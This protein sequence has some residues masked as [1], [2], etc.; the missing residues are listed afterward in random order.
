MVEER[1]AGET[2]ALTD[3][4]VRAALADEWRERNPQTPA[5]IAAFYRESKHLADDLTVFH[6][7]SGRQ[8]WTECIVWVAKEQGVRRVVDIG[9]G[10]GHDLKALREAIPGIDL[11]GI[12]P[13]ERLSASFFETSG[14]P[15]IPVNADVADAP[16]ES[17][18][19][20][21]MI[22]VLEHIPDPESFLTGVATRAPLGCFA[23]EATA[24]HDHGTPLH[25][26]A[27]WA[28]H[29]GHAFEAA[30]WERQTQEGRLRV[31]KRVRE[32]AEPRATLMLMAQSSCTLPTMRSILDLTAAYRDDGW[33]IYMGGEAGINRARNIAASRWYRETGDDVFVMVDHDI[34][35]TP[36]DV[37]RLVDRCRNGYPI[38][39][40]AYPVRDGGH[41]AMKAKIG[42]ITFGG[43]KEPVEIECVAT[44]FLA[45]HRR[46]IEAV[47]RDLPLCH[48]NT[49]WA[50]W[51]LFPFEVVENED[52]GGY[53]MLSE[54]YGWSRLAQRYGFKSYVD[55]S[56]ILR[57]LGTIPI[58]I[59][60]MGTV[61]Q[62]IKMVNG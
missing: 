35:F 38:I 39:C 49:E 12:E 11:C 62:A 42:Q 34:V 50:F 58:G 37:M 16:I 53:E 9:C 18:D 26:K 17:A 7:N 31:W 29:P 40:G 22:D 5:E 15:P 57:H 25:L 44:G 55:P 47:I 3:K 61:Q 36:A 8:R 46:V 1:P 10:L 45:V 21:I 56:I 48:A 23:V 4:Q 2:P 32:Q 27:N 52:A 54:D 41:L 30:G 13:N 20:L 60:N 6:S 59:P 33:R 24:T 14:T 19:M 51:N 43:E 28:W